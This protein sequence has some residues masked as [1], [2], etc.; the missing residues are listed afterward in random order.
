[1]SSI[2]LGLSYTSSS[3]PFASDFLSLVVFGISSLLLLFYSCCCILCNTFFEQNLRWSLSHLLLGAA[4]ASDS[5][6]PDLGLENIPKIPPYLKR[7]A[8]LNMV[9]VAGGNSANRPL[10]CCYHHPTKALADGFLVVYC[11]SLIE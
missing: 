2:T 3:S 11:S 7:Q 5:F 8:S 4:R 6:K 1:M 10:L 9:T